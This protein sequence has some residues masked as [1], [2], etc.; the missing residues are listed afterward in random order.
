MQ[1]IQHTFSSPFSLLGHYQ[2]PE[3]FYSLTTAVFEFVNCSI[4]LQK[5]VM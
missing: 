5:L 3:C 4:M 2:M 1:K